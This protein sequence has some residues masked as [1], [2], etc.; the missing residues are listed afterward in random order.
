MAKKLDKITWGIIYA[1]PLL[2]YVLSIFRLG[3]VGNF[4]DIAT[5]FAFE[6]INGILHDAFALFSSGKFLT[7]GL[8]E[9]LSFLMGATMAHLFIDVLLWLPRFFGHFADKGVFKDE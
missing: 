2:A 1:L 4:S 6:P 3:T 5:T 7:C 8:L 9:Y